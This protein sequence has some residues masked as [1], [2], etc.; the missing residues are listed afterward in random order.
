MR[1]VVGLAFVAGLLLS[2]GIGHAAPCPRP[3]ALGVARVLAVD[4]SNGLHVGRFQFPITLPLNPHEVVLTFDDGPNGR[5]TPRILDAL[6]NECTKAT[7]FMIGR[8]AAADPRTARAVALAGHT[9]GHHSM[10]HPAPMTLLLPQTAIND[11]ER[12]ITAVRTALGPQ[13]DSFAEGFFRY[14]GLW[15][16][17]AVDQWLASRGIGVFGIDVHALDWEIKDPEQ[18]VELAMARLEAQGRGILLLHDIQPV[19]AAALPELLR[20]LRV[21]GWHVVHIVPARPELRTTSADAPKTGDVARGVDADVEEEG[22]RLA[23]SPPPLAPR[24][25]DWRA[26]PQPV[27]ANELDDRAASAVFPQP[28]SHATR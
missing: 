16:P 9:I 15:N 18:I 24:R 19:T 23:Q 25:I 13:S 20:R 4:P 7:F 6:A 8:M 1:C 3:D 27:D 21:A 10:T 22:P 17:P 26:M 28:S 12:G 14:P 2:A 5:L 11:I